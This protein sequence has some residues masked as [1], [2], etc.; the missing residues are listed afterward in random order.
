MVKQ[1]ILVMYLHD[2]QDIT[3][4][5]KSVSGDIVRHAYQ[6]S[7]EGI[8]AIAEGRAVVVIV[9]AQ[10]V[11]LTSVSVPTTNRATYLQAVPFALEEQLVDEIEDL[12]F[13]I[14]ERPMENR[15]SVAVVA[16]AKMAQWLSVL[17]SMHIVPDCLVPAQLVLPCQE[18]EWSVFI[19]SQVIVR[20][21][22]F[23]GF[24]CAEEELVSFLNAG[25][26]GLEVL[27]QLVVT[28][29]GRPQSA[30]QLNV[31]VSLQQQE[32]PQVQWA[33]DLARDVT[34]YP[35]ID[36]LQGKYVVKK[37]RPSR[38]GTLWKGAVAA[39]AA[40]LFLLLLGPT[41][42]YLM[43]GPRIRTLNTEIESFYRHRF[44]ATTSFSLQDGHRKM[45]EKLAQLHHQMGEDRFWALLGDTSR[46]IQDAPDVHLRRIHFQHHTLALE[47]VAGSSASFSIFTE[48]L[49]KHG[50]SVKQQ[51]ANLR[52]DQ[53]HVG[54]LV[55]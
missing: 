22:P 30:I 43:I 25:L 14:G 41:V 19:A 15:L 1:E 20:T 12:H 13:A 49:Q 50:H 38:L 37:K 36:L 28:S 21:G 54:L 42:S 23:M 44:P 55:E 53:L 3:W 32:C 7:A 40:W 45:Q 5:I 11:L 18:G 26:S 29:Y 6:D 34:L 2:N 8:S 52:G 47:L 9:P 4:A 24:G 51:H 17:H 10:D 48:H 46:A 39:A 31:P 27:P 35:S 33:Y 16:K